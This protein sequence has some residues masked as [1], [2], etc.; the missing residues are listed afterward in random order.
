LWHE[1]IVNKGREIVEQAFEI[2][3]TRM[4]VDGYVVGPKLSI[5]DAALFYVEFWADK[6]GLT[7]P[8]RCSAHYQRMRAR[9]VVRRVLIEEGYR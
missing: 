1:A 4:P 7:L 3:E 5:A 6:T 8:P 9:P 2:I